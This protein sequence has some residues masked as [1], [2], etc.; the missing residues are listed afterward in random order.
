MT[1]DDTRSHSNKCVVS[2]MTGDTAES[3]VDTNA[4]V[5]AECCDTDGRETVAGEATTEP[6]V[7]RHPSQRQRDGQQQHEHLW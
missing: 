2:V 4:H 7:D 3:G 1:Q 5:R 6:R